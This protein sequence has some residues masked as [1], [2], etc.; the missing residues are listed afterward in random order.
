MTDN[1]I[2]DD[3]ID[4][5]QPGGSMPWWKII[6]LAVIVVVVGLYALRMGAIAIAFAFP[7][8]PP[9]P[10]NVEEVEYTREAHGMD[11]WEYHRVPSPCDTI[12]FYEEQGATCTVEVGYCSEEPDAELLQESALA[13]TCTGEEA[14]AIFVMG[15]EA[16]IFD[17]PEETRI[18]VE[19]NIPWT[20]A[21]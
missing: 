4:E 11:S 12:R 18:M 6:L 19:R 20:R 8:E 15:W 5:N 9:V 10:N 3:V 17:F 14:F 16:E 1:Q 13:A 2:P 21:R 7:P